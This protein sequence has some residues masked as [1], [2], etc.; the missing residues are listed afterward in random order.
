MGGI[1]IPQLAIM[2]TLFGF[3]AERAYVSYQKHGAVKSSDIIMPILLTIAVVG[4]LFIF[5]NRITLNS[6]V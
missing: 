3:V 4:V 2:L 1:K 6:I 5:Y